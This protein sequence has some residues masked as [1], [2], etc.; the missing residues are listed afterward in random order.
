MA[1][2][3]VE[4]VPGYGMQR[5]VEDLVEAGFIAVEAIRIASY[6]G[7]ECEGKLDR[8]GSIA[9]GKPPTSSCSAAIRRRTSNESKRSKSY[10]RTALRSTR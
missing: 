9:P 8:I 5:E 6:N 2:S 3:D 7:A 10:S 4:T 1:G